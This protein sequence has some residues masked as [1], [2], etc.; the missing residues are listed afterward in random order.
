MAKVPVAEI[1]LQTY[2]ILL[3]IIATALVGWVGV[4]LKEQKKNEK[5]REEEAKKK[6]VAAEQ[7]RHA[8]STGIMLVLRYMLKRYHSEY[9]IQGRITYA[10]YRDWI[11][12]FKAY[13]AL[14]GNSIAED[15]NDDIETMEKCESVSD[16]SPFEA[17][18]RKTVED[19]CDKK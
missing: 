16:M 10:Q 11:D 18:L 9:M 13:T 4:L 15:W 7:I 6:E 8:N 1:L 19:G 14:G 2:Y 17:M 12:L 3:P 5:A